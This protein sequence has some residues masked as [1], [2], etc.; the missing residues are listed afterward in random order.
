MIK[1]I[2]EKKILITGGHST[3]AFA[4]LDELK[5]RGYKN[6]VWVSEKH[7]QKGNKATSAEFKTITEIY[8]IKFINITAGKLVR[9]WVIKN[10]L[11]D[12]TNFTKFFIGFI[13]GLYIQLRYKPQTVI[14]F[15]GFLAFPSVFWTKVFRKK[16]ITHEQTITIGLANKLISKFADKVLLSFKDE[17]RLK[18][19]K[20]IFTGNPLRKAIFEIKSNI[21]ESLDSTKPTL[22]I[23]GGNQG[24]NEINTRVFEILNTLLEHF[25]IIH[26]TGNST[27]TNDHSKAIDIKKSLQAEK[28]ARYI[29]RDYVYSD[30]IGEVL[31]K[32]DILLTRAGANT[33]FEIIALNKLAIFIP[34]PWVSMNEQFK[35]AEYVE[36]I[37]LGK[38]LNQNDLTAEEIKQVLL[39]SVNFI[40]IK[41][42]FNGTKLEDSFNN[43]KK[44]VN[45]NAAEMIVDIIEDF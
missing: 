7:N 20:Y 6:F 5:K 21:T 13:Q 24:A 34:I 27:V 30:E 12:I 15:G 35:N 1:S 14:S 9:K 3:P 19:N 28:Q 11:S 29:V 41:E 32:A 10:F 18:N 16:V 33:V 8:K 23:T 22:Y 4:V 2:K 40:N 26:Q 31:N 45:L 39:D 25:N 44:L 38:I 37:G 17:T 42:N 36:S 43:T